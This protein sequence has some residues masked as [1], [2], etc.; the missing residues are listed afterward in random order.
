MS[1]RKLLKTPDIA[2]SIYRNDLERPGTTG[3]ALKFRMNASTT[4]GD[5][6]VGASVH[7]VDSGAVALA[8]GFVADDQT[9]LQL[10]A[11]KSYDLVSLAS[12]AEL[13]EEDRD[14]IVLLVGMLAVQ[15]RDGSDVDATAYLEGMAKGGF[16]DNPIQTPPGRSPQR[17]F[18]LLEKLKTHEL[19]LLPKFTYV[20]LAEPDQV[21]E[22]PSVA[23]KPPPR[24]LPTRCPGCGKRL[25]PTDVEPVSGTCKKCHTVVG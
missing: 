5:K 19:V 17:F 4:E 11:A 1:R 2:I 16:K 25:K 9:Q 8:A 21:E 3:E 12:R 15:V 6:I 14:L 20:E 23:P 7:R 10:T 13:A 22:P 24:T 18:E